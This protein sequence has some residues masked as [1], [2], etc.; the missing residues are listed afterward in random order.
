MPVRGWGPPL[1][2]RVAGNIP[3]ELNSFVGRRHELTDVR[4]MLGMSSLVTLTGHGGVGKTRLAARAARTFGKSFPDGVWMVELADVRDAGLIPHVVADTLGMREQGGEL[5]VDALVEFIA[6][7][8]VLIVLDNCEHVINEAALLVDRLRHACPELRILVTSR[9]PLNVLGEH[10]LPVPTLSVPDPARPPE[11]GGMAGFEAVALFA[12]RAQAALPSF[13]ISEANR[14]AV[15][16][17]VN[18][19]DGVPLA[20]EL[21]AARLRALSVSELADH[22]AD[23]GQLRMAGNRNATVR[24]RTLRQCIQWSHDQCSPAEQTLWARL[25]VFDGVFGIEDAEQ[26]CGFGALAPSDILEPLAGLVDKSVITRVETAPARYRLLEALREFGLDRLQTS[27]YEESRSRHMEWYARLARQARDEWIS[28]RQLAWAA[29]LSRDLPNLRA[30]F[31]RS[32]LEPADSRVKLDIQDSLSIFWM[33]HGVTEGRRW[34]G[35]ALA[36]YD[37]PPCIELLKAIFSGVT[38]AGFQGDLDTVSELADR[39]RAV[40]ANM[41]DDLAAAVLTHVEGMRATYFGDNETALDLLGDAVAAFR[42]SGESLRLVEALITLSYSAAFAGDLNTA[43]AC[44]NEI[45]AISEPAGEVMA[46]AYCEWIYGLVAWLEG[47]PDR[48]GAFERRS[49]RSRLLMN[50]VVGAA[51]CLEAMAIIELSAHAPER[52]AK[53][54][55]AAMAL[56]RT[57]SAQ[58]VSFPLLVPVRQSCEADARKALGEHVFDKIYT[59]GTALGF[60]NA[61]SFALGEDG[62]TETTTAS[63]A[64]PLTKREREVA[65]LIADGLK[66]REIAERL[67]IAERTAQGH[68]ENILTKLGFNSRTQV[69]AWVVEHLR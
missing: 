69:A 48:A 25:S 56:S 34:I 17:I 30:A 45:L 11:L 27:D 58:S 54:L 36:A 20:L 18:E 3:S 21:V 60:D 35:R 42:E 68:V 64:S 6:D 33:A 43:K 53:L 44:L 55:G 39:A 10:V 49:L 51:W 38:L 4:R 15:V 31:D 7:R 46:K 50:D 47:D 24:H 5:S 26:V 8:R 16:R 40:E 14:V 62:P 61:V 57:A 52:A 13:S 29:R 67:V 41:T 66:N 2:A 1:S 19:L 12:D 23:H 59:E 32:L 28:D 65:V 63:V 22:L 9:E 37:G